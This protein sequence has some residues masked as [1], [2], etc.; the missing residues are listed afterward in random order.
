MKYFSNLK[1]K[2]NSFVLLKDLLLTKNNDNSEIIMFK[3]IYNDFATW[4][5]KNKAI[6]V[7]TNKKRQMK[8]L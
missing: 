2:L 1:G 7:I 8:N 3:K 4:F 6:R 5:I